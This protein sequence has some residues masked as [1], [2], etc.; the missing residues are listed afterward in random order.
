MISYLLLYC[1]RH[2]NGER[3]LAAVYH[4]LTGKKSAQ[5]L[6]DS[7]WFQLERVFGIYKTL[8]LVEIEQA[9]MQLLRKQ[10]IVSVDERSYVLT[11]AGKEALHEWLLS[12]TFFTHLNGL[13]Y[14]TVDRLFWYRLSLTVQTLS[15]LV[16][17][18]K[19]I[20]IHRHE[21]TFAWV[22]TYL[23]AKNP[24]ALAQ[25]LHQE[26]HTICSSLS[27][28]EATIFTLRLTSFERIGW[29]NEQIAAFLQKDP[30][31]VQ[32]TFQHL[33]HYMMKR[34]EREPKQFPILHDVIK[35]LVKPV[36]LTLSAQKTY[37]WLIKGKTIGEIAR[38]RNLKPNTIED[39]VVEIA[40]NV[41]DFPITP[42]VAEET[43]R[44]IIEA[45]TRLKTRQLK[46]LRDAVGEEISYFEIRL[47][48]AKVGE[49][50][51]S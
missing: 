22:K 47:V 36:S 11:E 9:A 27:E 37:E 32:L 14:D 13:L 50:S 46:K 45:A 38:I 34:A 28:E 41:R 30:L 26:L 3:S 6:Q 17:R 5:T 51:V 15:N 8:S 43:R 42:F 35:D 49:N 31:Y 21:A 48:L 44:K 7:K 40:A 12:V 33:L 18:R 19:F 10:W 20:P 23:M 25:A 24:H 16:H 2:F 29:T 1:L 39:H 4:L